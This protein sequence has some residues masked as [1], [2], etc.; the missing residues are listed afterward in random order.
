MAAAM[1]TIKVIS[2]KTSG[3][4]YVS[5]AVGGSLGAAATALNHVASA[6]DRTSDAK[7]PHLRLVRD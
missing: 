4:S 7:R 6:S 3:K 2:A 1:P 5:V